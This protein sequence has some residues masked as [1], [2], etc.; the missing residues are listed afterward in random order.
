M[1]DTATSV[2]DNVGTGVRL[3]A[4]QHV[5]RFIPAEFLMISCGCVPVDPRARKI[6]I[7]YDRDS[8]YTQLPKGRK[9]I[10]EDLHA[11]AIRETCEETGL[12]FHPLPLKNTTRATPSD[13]M[14]LEDKTLTVGPNGLTEGLV[15]CEPSSVCV[16]RCRQTHSFK[17]IFWFA[18]KGDCTAKQDAST[19]EA[20]EQGFELEW[21]EARDAAAR[22]SDEADGKVIEKVLADMRNT[23]YDI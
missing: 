17:M 7:I 19:R 4:D 5:Q 18:A 11:T 10:H 3:S 6:A 16:Y 8:G 1:A 14:M 13:S 9:N 23:G 15:N 12:E 22:M 2:A 20:W 21:V